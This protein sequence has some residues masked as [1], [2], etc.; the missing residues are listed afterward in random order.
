MQWEPDHGKVSK[1]SGEPYGAS[2][3]RISGPRFLK[4]CLALY[5]LA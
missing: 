2:Y 5:A 1:T 4:I 3:L